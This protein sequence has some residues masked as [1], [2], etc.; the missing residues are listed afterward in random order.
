M[1][2]EEGRGPPTFEI[3]GQGF[4]LNI[5]G[6]SYKT[7]ACALAIDHPSRSATGGKR[8]MGQSPIDRMEIMDR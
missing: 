6:R 3:G 5:C 7:S 8:V 2:R 1:I 4:I